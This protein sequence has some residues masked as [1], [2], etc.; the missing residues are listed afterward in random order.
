MNFH[1]YSF[2]QVINQK[3]AAADAAALFNIPKGQWSKE[4]SNFINILTTKSDQQL[5]QIFTEYEHIAAQDIETTIKREFK[6]SLEAYTAIS[7]LA[8]TTRG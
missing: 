2:P 1:F 5:F 8:P 7:K 3:A 4:E 6:G